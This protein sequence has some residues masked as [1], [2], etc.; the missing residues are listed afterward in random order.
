MVEQIGGTPNPRSGVPDL[1][2]VDIHALPDFQGDPLAAY[3]RPMESGSWALTTVAFG[4]A[5][6]Y[7]SGL[8][9]VW[10]MPVLT[11]G[12]DVWMSIC[13]MEVES[14]WIGIDNASGHTVI[15]GL[16]M[17]WAAAM[18]AFHPLVERITVIERDTEVI[19]LNR[20]L[21]LFDRLP[22]GLGAKITVVEDDAF[23]WKPDAPVDL[24]MPDIWLDVVSDGRAE[25]TRRM[26]DNIGAKTVYFWGQELELAR[27]IV[28]DGKPICDAT[29]EEAAEQFAL[30]LIGLDTED[31]AANTITATRQWMKGRWLD[32]TDIPED[33]RSKADNPERF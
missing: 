21:G 27:H 33:L 30:P 11:R 18:A 8:Q 32:G 10:N 24:L 2:G 25:E 20:E 23:T 26:Q 6:G 9:R 1:A 4:V 7:F 22:D 3:Y 13:P 19:E 5:M 12:Q 14:Q 28:R 29:L 16:G 31:Y 17:G 15:V